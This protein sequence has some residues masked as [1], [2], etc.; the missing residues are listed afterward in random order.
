MSDR[1]RVLIADDHELVRMGFKSMLAYEGDIDVV[2]EAAD[3]AEAVEVAQRLEPDVV[4]MDLLLPGVGGAEATH[5]VAWDQGAD[6]HLVREFGG[7][8]AGGEERRDGRA[9]EGVSVGD[10]SCG[11][12]HGGGGRDVLRGRGRASAR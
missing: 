1:I 11:V 3:G 4:V 6:R 7:H 10:A 9:A 8:P 12:A 2:G 5:S